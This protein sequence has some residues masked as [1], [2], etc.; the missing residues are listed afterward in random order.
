[1]WAMKQSRCHE[2]YLPKSFQSEMLREDRNLTAHGKSE[3]IENEEAI[4]GEISK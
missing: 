3:F 1:M 2:T 4:L